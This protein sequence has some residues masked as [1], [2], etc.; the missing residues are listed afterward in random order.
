VELI[1][2]RSRHLLIVIAIVVVVLVLMA[3]GVSYFV[4]RPVLRSIRVVTGELR[5]LAA[6]EFNL[7]RRLHVG[8]GD[9][10][11]ALAGAFNALLEKLA[12]LVSNVRR[13]AASVVTRAG[14][15]AGN[16][17]ALEASV[18][19]QRVSTQSTT[20]AAR[21]IAATSAELRR[22]TG[23]IAETAAQTNT[24]VGAGKDVL[25]RIGASMGALLEANQQIVAK[26][27]VINDRVTQI[28][29]MA[30]AIRRVTD[31]TNLLSLNAGIEAIKAGDRGLGFTVVAQEI[32]RL[33]DQSADSTIEI[34]Q[35]IREVR[36]AVDA[37][38]MEMDRFRGR[39]NEATGDVFAI[40]EQLGGM[41]SQ[42]Q[43]L[44]PLLEDVRATFG[45]Q[46]EGVQQINEAMV[47]LNEKVTAT[48]EALERARANRAQVEEAGK[49]LQKLVEEMAM[50][51]KSGHRW[52][53]SAMMACKML[54]CRTL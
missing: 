48:A 45:A 14:E 7:G 32:R 19:Q 35:V 34:E 6:G 28:N 18:A 33:A 26:L 36:R 53:Q 30:D 39:L 17:A 49:R 38:V 24:V 13:E 25:S 10:I 12:A 21:E 41:I 3:V 47:A 42:V 50:L 31:H 2:A 15:M 22:N 11:S 43:K 20:V 44:L 1:E 16:L 23:H 9:E 46:D 5:E 51:P 40:Q 4:Q 27:S 37:G 54:Y 29:A 8:G 52:L